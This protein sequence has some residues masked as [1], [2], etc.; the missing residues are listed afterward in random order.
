MWRCHK[1]AGHGLVDARRALQWS[2]DTWFYKVADTLGLDP[3]A[4]VGRSFGLGAPTG[5]AVVAEVPGIMP[6]SAYHDRVTPGGYTKGMALNSVI[7]QGDVNVTPL[8]LTM[9]YAAV[10]NGGHLYKPQLVRRLETPDGRT[11]QEFQPQVIRELDLDPEARAL[12]VDALAS[13]V[14]EAGGTGYRSRLADVRIAGKTGTAQ[15][16][17]IGK[18]RLKKEAMTY[19][20]RDHAWFAAFAP[21]ED[22]EIA[23]VVINEHAGHGGN[24][25][26]P[27]ASALIKK[28]FEL[29]REDTTATI[30]A[31]SA[32]PVMPVRPAPPPAVRPPPVQEELPPVP[33]EAPSVAQVPAAPSE[34]AR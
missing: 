20:Q 6:D 33:A 16:V 22:P 7:G 12:V 8:Q 23:V 28:Y 18:T 26:A 19:W 9:A 21:A 27:A 10:A 32:L 14:N 24:E 2:C 29:K 15:V 34:G 5:V 30:A 11:L 1:D 4:A 13:V 17:A 31:S 25:A 3:I